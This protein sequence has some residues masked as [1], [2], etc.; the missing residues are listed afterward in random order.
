M[1]VHVL[2]YASLQNFTQCLVCVTNKIPKGTGGASALLF[3]SLQTSML[4]FSLSLY[5]CCE[6][7]FSKIHV[8]AENTLDFIRM[9]YR[10]HSEPIKQNF[11]NLNKLTHLQILKPFY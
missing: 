11:R 1:E 3:P 10:S 5:F 8:C 4:T 2:I 6:L 7:S 9:F